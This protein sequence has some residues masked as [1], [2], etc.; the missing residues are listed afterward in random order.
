M[1]YTT[2][3]LGGA[4]SNLHGVSVIYPVHNVRMASESISP[5]SDRHSHTLGNSPFYGPHLEVLSGSD[6]AGAYRPHGRICNSVE[7][8][9][10]GPHRIL[11]TAQDL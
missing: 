8:L 5:Y 10:L 3:E 7:V 11:N 1:A 2:T 9:Y 4:A 6:D